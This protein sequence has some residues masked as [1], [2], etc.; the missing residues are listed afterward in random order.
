MKSRLLILVASCIFFLSSGLFL[1][2]LFNRPYSPQEFAARIA[3]NLERELVHVDNDAALLLDNLREKQS[4]EIEL[5]T[6][7]PFF[8][9]HGQELVSWTDNRF[10]PTYASVADT[11]SLKLLK[12]GSGDYLASKWKINN[13]RFVVAIIPLDRK[14]NISN[15]YLSNWRNDQVV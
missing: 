12:A 4:N 15:N 3:K 14:Y 9:Y 6:S 5:E 2:F 13:N 10:V 11:F 1:L 7:C 8:V